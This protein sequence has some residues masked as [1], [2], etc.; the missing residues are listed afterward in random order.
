MKTIEK[1]YGPFDKGEIEFYMKSLYTESTDSIINPFQKSLVFNL[2]YNYFGNPT[3]INAI[4]KEDYVKLLISAKR[5]LQ[6]NNMVILPYIISSKVERLVTRNNVNKKELTKLE[7]SPH[8]KN[9]VEKYKNDKY[10]RDAKLG[11][12]RRILSN[13]YIKSCFD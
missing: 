10:P 8:Y 9:I 5:I 11:L 6:A 3:S 12:S 2:F 1:L 13:T 4:N 7:Q